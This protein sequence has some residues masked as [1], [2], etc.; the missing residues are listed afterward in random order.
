MFCAVKE[1]CKSPIEGIAFLTIIKEDM[2]AVRENLKPWY[3]LV[4]TVPGT[5]SFHHIVSTSIHYQGKTVE[6]QQKRLHHPFPFG[7][8][9]TTKWDSWAT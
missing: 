5:W 2:V 7:H 6:Y 8:A 9:S 3:E 4:D 1:Y